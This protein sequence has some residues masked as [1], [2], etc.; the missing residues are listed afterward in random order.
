MKKAMNTASETTT[1]RQLREKK[2]ANSARCRYASAA[3]P[4]ASASA[5]AISV[6]R[7]LGATRETLKIQAAYP[8][9]RIPSAF[10]SPYPL[11]ASLG[12]RK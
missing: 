3:P 2:S 1:S 6:S 8:T 9:T 7:T 5:T 4:T 10:P 12:S 11:S